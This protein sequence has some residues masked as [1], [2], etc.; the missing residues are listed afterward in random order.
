MEAN[1]GIL[2]TNVTAIAA[3][4]NLVIA[5]TE[6]TGI[7]VSTDA[8]NNWIRAYNGLTSVYV[9]AVTTNNSWSFASVLNT[10]VF[11]TNNNGGLWTSASTGLAASP[12]SF[13]P[14]SS[15]IL[16][17]TQGQQFTP[18]A[19]Y[20]TVDNGL[21]WT[22]IPDPGIGYLSAIGLLN[23]HIYAGTDTGQVFVTNTNGASWQNIS[24]NL[25]YGSI[26]S[27]LP[28]NTDTVFVALATSG[29]YVTMNGGTSWTTANTGITNLNITDIRFLNGVLYTST[30]G[31]G[32][33]YSLNMGATWTAFNSGLDDLYVSEIASNTVNLYTA[34]DAGVYSTT[35]IVNGIQNFRNSIMTLYPNPSTGKFYMS[36]LL[37]GKTQIKI[38]NAVGEVVYEY[39]GFPPNY[40]FVVL[41]EQPAGIYFLTLQN[42]KQLSVQKIILQKE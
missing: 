36:G 4:N 32:V 21:H 9:L 23:Q 11:R 27:I 18:P 16:A 15:R 6:G 19:I 31:G 28:I 40:F 22:A 7:Y 26:K 34:T 8:G 41:I 10:K 25:P 2:A 5:G 38:Y 1:N 17:L 37:N 30:S 42:E 39:D 35:A 13:L 33:F 29:I 12:K 24:S 14:D 20:E 3:D